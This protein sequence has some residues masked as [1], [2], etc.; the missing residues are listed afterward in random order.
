M[1]HGAAG[2]AAEAAPGCA[3]L[4]GGP[5]RHLIRV[6]GG[7]ARPVP[8]DDAPPGEGHLR[9][10]RVH[11]H[12]YAAVLLRQG[13]P[14]F[15]AVQGHC[16]APGEP[17]AHR[18]LQAAA[19]GLHLH[20]GRIGVQ[21]D[22]VYPGLSQGFAV[23]AQQ[24]EAQGV[25]ALLLGGAAAAREQHRRA[26]VH[27]HREGA[28]LGQGIQRR[29][30]HQA[31]DRR[32]IAPAVSRP[33]L[34][35][36]GQFGFRLGALA[37]GFHPHEQ[38]ILPGHALVL[39][40]NPHHA[41][42]VEHVGVRQQGLA[43]QRGE[44]PVQHD[45]LARA[46]VDGPV[47]LA[48]QLFQGTPGAHALHQR[49]GLGGGGSVPGRSIVLRRDGIVI[50]ILRRS[51][52]VHRLLRL[53]GLI[54]GIFVGCGVLRI[55]IISFRQGHREAGG[56]GQQRTVRSQQGEAVLAG[57]GGRIAVARDG[58]RLAAVQDHRVGHALPDGREGRQREG[59]TAGG[60]VV[61]VMGHDL[62]FLLQHL[63]VRAGDRVLQ[64]VAGGSRLLALL[65]RPEEEGVLLHK[66]VRIPH[67]QVDAVILRREDLPVQGEGY[68]RQRFRRVPLDLH[69]RRGVQ[70]HGQPQRV[71][72]V[73]PAVDLHAVLHHVQRAVGGGG[74]GSSGSVR[75]HG[76]VRGH[77]F[78][79]GYGLIRGHGII[80]G[81]RIVRGH[82]IIRGHRFVRG[83][84]LSAARFVQIAGGSQGIS[85]R[86]ACHQAQGQDPCND[87]FHSAAP[88]LLM[89]EQP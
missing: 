12:G 32:D 77:R 43:R 68:L 27:R 80:R 31:E 61:I 75:G 47:R 6:G 44:A 45:H 67:G 56:A 49:P 54:A 76:I 29:L 71:Q 86:T 34:R 66:A 11:V 85:Q 40:G 21:P 59:G 79:R 73:K 83:H 82:G 62:D 48:Q 84:G 15:A 65:P 78:V 23:R 1:G 58:L 52:V 35:R 37:P 3:R 14:G 88:F 10:R 72:R 2:R 53:D 89:A 87:S 16:V 30:R 81:H 7:V 17:V 19:L 46:D 26:A 18:H 70:H 74:G 9:L 38:G 42:L 39:A 5:Q 24:A 36:H 25:V 20:E 63:L 50:C 60:A 8:H 4:G 64:R 51:G 69:H 28:A 55:L 57:N 22:T 33:A 13:I 41:F